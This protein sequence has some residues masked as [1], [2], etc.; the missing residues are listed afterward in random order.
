MTLEVH[1][2]QG[3]ARSSRLLQSFSHTAGTKLSVKCALSIP[4][5]PRRD[6]NDGSRSLGECPIKPRCRW[7]V[8]EAAIEQV[9]GLAELLRRQ[10]LQ[11]RIIGQI[12]K[13]MIQPTNRYSRKVPRRVGGLGLSLRLI[14]RSSGA[15]PSETLRANQKKNGFLQGGFV[16]RSSLRSFPA[17][18]SSAILANIGM[19]FG[20]TLGRVLSKISP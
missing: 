15:R 9:A 18:G 1:N 6:L 2:L 4:I 14:S 19:R 8:L 13:P 20:I 10:E 12:V 16:A 3:A 17:F 5:R 7:W 11:P